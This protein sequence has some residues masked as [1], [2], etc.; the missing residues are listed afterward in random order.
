MT[1]LTPV[2][3]GQLVSFN[4]D[5][6]TLALIRM[7]AELAFLLPE[8]RTLR[9]IN[10]RLDITGTFGGPDPQSPESPMTSVPPPGPPPV[11]TPPPGPPPVV[12]PPPEPPPVVTPPV[13]PITAP[14]PPKRPEKH[15][16]R[17]DTIPRG[18]SKKRKKLEKEIDRLKNQDPT[19]PL[20]LGEDKNYNIN[21]EQGTPEARPSLLDEVDSL[22]DIPNTDIPEPGNPKR[23]K[24]LDNLSKKLKKISETLAEQAKKEK[25][26]PK[27]DFGEQP[28]H[29]VIDSE[30]PPFDLPKEPTLPDEAE[31]TKES[32][33]EATLPGEPKYSKTTPSSFEIPD[34][35]P[36]PSLRKSNL[37]GKVRR[38]IRDN[39][40]AAIPLPGNEI[41]DEGLD[42]L[43]KYGILDGAP[44]REYNTFSEDL[45]QQRGLL[46]K[47]Y[48]ERPE[49]LAPPKL[50]YGDMLNWNSMARLVG[51]KDNVDRNKE[52]R[53]MRAPRME[54]W[55][56]H[57]QVQQQ[58]FKNKLDVLGQRGKNLR[59]RGVSQASRNKLLGKAA[60]LIVS[61]AKIRV[62]GQTTSALQ[63]QK[64]IID[65]FISSQGHDQDV[66][67]QM[68]KNI[69]AILQ[70]KLNVEEDIYKSYNKGL[71]SEEE[72]QRELKKVERKAQL[73]VHKIL[74]EGV[75]KRFT[76]K[77]EEGEKRKT[78][79]NKFTAKI[80]G[81]KI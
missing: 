49:M 39:L 48:A 72:A 3:R 13:P 29:D 73:D 16:K 71:L 19:L 74:T 18:K 40:T 9:A 53:D 60:D 11:V 79:R 6:S 61:N 54:N 5:L 44:D 35:T 46:D 76:K 17:P 28:T 63:K 47:L 55:R 64:G 31:P 25:K 38:T 20:V 78:D 56:A 22:G 26:K 62:G 70:K 59:A 67:K 80:K 77:T 68:N 75:D 81:D 15:K 34:E 51:M 41:R 10:A 27:A 58:D 1:I 23:P 37:G 4:Q 30:E 52:V 8:V 66:T 2:I 42:Q 14:V 24:A 45:S 43:K 50:N 7:L 12:T 69:S 32:V 57:R 65:S 21:F 33:G 36:N